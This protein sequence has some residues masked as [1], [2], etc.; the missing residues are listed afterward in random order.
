MRKIVREGGA[1]YRYLFYLELSWWH[2][3]ERWPSQK[4]PRTFVVPRA[5]ASDDAD[6]RVG[7]GYRTVKYA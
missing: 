3:R 1:R 7:R 2:G 5:G 6:F 4:M